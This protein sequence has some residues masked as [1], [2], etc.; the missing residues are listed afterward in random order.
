MKK[1]KTYESFKQLE[2]QR[3]KT[4]LTNLCEDLL[5]SL[6]DRGF[7]IIIDVNIVSPLSLSQSYIH[8][9]I[10]KQVDIDN[11]RY[12][13][14]NEISNEEFYTQA[15][16]WNEI[17]SDVERLNLALINLGFKPKGEQGNFHSVSIRNPIN[18]QVRSIKTTIDLWYS[19]V[20]TSDIS[21]ELKSD[22]YQRA[23]DILSKKGHTKRP[24][25]LKKWADITR[26]KE[27]EARK[28]AIL[29]EA[30]RFSNPM[31]VEIISK[32]GT[33]TGLFYPRLSFD[34]DRL[35]DLWH[36]FIRGDADLWLCFSIGFIPADEETKGKVDK[37]GI[38]NSDGI[39]YIGEME[40]HLLNGLGSDEIELFKQDP[41]I[42]PDGRVSIDYYQDSVWMKIS[43]RKSAVEF[44]KFLIN[45]FSSSYVY[46][47]DSK[48]TGGLVHQLQDELCD[49]YN[50]DY[51]G[52]LQFLS[53]IKDININSLYK[54]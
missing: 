5:L 14:N 45:V 42:N 46:R 54:D 38:A 51:D 28:A 39:C 11:S 18:F 12:G 31:E 49:H 27:T 32:E 33:Q 24:A 43:K 30:K 26:K 13:N 40:M 44:K 1:L 21:E 15:F 34:R 50:I 53:K 20:E 41:K 25:E 23:A 52:F 2:S 10:S 22:V 36:D 48:Y 19:K 8:I 3:E 17:E 6:S 4:D 47:P 16:N 35:W 7:K 37:L 29:E 9:Q